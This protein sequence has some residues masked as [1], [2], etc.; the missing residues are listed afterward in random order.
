MRA[1][2][3]N[4]QPTF[5]ATAALD[6]HEVA[7][8]R[9]RGRTRGGTYLVRI[10]YVLVHAHARTPP[11]TKHACEC[12]CVQTR[13]LATGHTPTRTDRCMRACFPQDTGARAISIASLPE[14][15]DTPLAASV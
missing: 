13:S 10:W 4:H 15:L 6:G 3:P 5:L 12:A 14:R 11:S 8:V 7:E 9:T 1:G 2:M